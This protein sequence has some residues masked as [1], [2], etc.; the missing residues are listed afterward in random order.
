MLKNTEEILKKY[1]SEYQ[2]HLTTRNKIAK[3]LQHHRNILHFKTIPKC[4]LPPTPE[5]VTPN[6]ILVNDFKMEYQE[7]FFQHLTKSISHIT[8]TLELKNARLQ[9]LIIRTETHLSS[10]QASAE[11]IEQLRH[12]FY[13]QNHDTKCPVRYTKI[14]QH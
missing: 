2:Q 12:H 9:E 13:T 3:A 11:A 4:Y 7:L 6:P 1:L 14:L 8:I 5:I 10:L